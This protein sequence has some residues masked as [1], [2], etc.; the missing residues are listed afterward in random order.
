MTNLEALELMQYDP[1]EKA[2]RILFAEGYYSTVAHKEIFPILINMCKYF[3]EEMEKRSLRNII[4]T[5]Y[6]IHLEHLIDKY[7]V[8]DKDNKCSIM[9]INDIFHQV[10]TLIYD[11]EELLQLS[12]FEIDSPDLWENLSYAIDCLNKVIP[13]DERPIFRAPYFGYDESS[14]NNN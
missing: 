5:A 2:E 6:V 4:N 10:V 7:Q 1:I 9:I 11:K 8:Y 13:L 12:H 3:P 14:Q